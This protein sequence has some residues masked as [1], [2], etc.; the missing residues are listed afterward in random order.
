M[1][2]SDRKITHW[3]EVQLSS[4]LLYRLHR[5]TALDR[6]FLTAASIPAEFKWPLLH[7]AY[8]LHSC[9]HYYVCAAV[10][11]LRNAIEFRESIGEKESK[12]KKKRQGTETGREKIYLEK[13]TAFQPSSLN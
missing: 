6:L 13:N 5:K 9:F 1:I 11:D 4:R 7:S 12:W 10:L 8:F 2:A 3:F